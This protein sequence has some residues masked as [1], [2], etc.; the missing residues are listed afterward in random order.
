M[1]EEQDRLTGIRR[2]HAEAIASDKRVR[3]AFAAVPREAFL[4]PGPWIT[5][6]GGGYSK[7]P[8]ADPARVYTDHL[9]ALDAKKGINNGQPSLH[10]SWMAAVAP[11]PGETVMQAGAGMGY[12]TAILSKLVSP[13]GHVLAYELEPALAEAARRN[14]RNYPGVTVI[15]GDATTA[16]MAPSDVIYVNAG[17]IAPPVAWLHALKP[18]GRMIFPWR[19]TEDV[20]LTI[21]VTR[22]GDRFKAQS[23]GSAW[24]IPC[25]GASS[26][27]HCLKVPTPGGARSV[28]SIWLT[29]DRPPDGTAVAVYTSVWFS[30]AV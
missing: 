28:A 15:T 14:L 30:K 1:P 20:G 4:P 13:D 18:N 8:D 27:T 16:D 17:V 22:L 26:P 7:T 19:P 2:R 21:L 11:Q 29:E 5:T 10:A 24:F 12:Y 6:Q 25:V 23:L 3:S 9:F